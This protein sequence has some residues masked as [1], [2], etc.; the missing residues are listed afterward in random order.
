MVPIMSERLVLILR[1]CR[2]VFIVALFTSFLGVPAGL[3]QYHLSANTTIR[4]DSPRQTLQSF[5]ALGREL[6]LVLQEYQNNRTSQVRARISRIGDEFLSLIDLSSVPEASRRKRGLETGYYLLDILGRI[7]PP[8]FEDVPGANSFDINV[9]KP[10]KWRIPNTPIEIVRMR[11]GPRLGEFLFGG[12]TVVTAPQFYQEIKNLK[13]KSILPIQSWSQTLPQLT[14]PMLPAGLASSMPQILRRPWL[15]TP[16][17]KILGVLALSVVSISVIIIWNHFVWPRQSDESLPG[18]FR[19]LLTPVLIIVLMGALEN[20]VAFQ[21]N[22]SGAFAT[23]FSSVATLVTY[24]A[25][26]W[27]LWLLISLLVEAIIRSPNIPDQSLDAS[28][29][30]LC[31]RIL[32]IV[33]GVGILAYAGN[34]LGLPVFSLIAGLGIGGIA[35]ALAVRPTLENLVGG[36]ILYADRPVRVGDYCGFGNYIG[37]IESIGMRSTQVRALDRTLI[38]VPNAKFAD[39]EIVNWAHCDRMLINTTIGL[40]YETEADHLRYVLAK[41]REML[42]AHPK[43]DKETVRVR[44]S[45]YGASSLDVDIRVYALTREWNEFYAIREDVLLRV[46]EIVTNSGTGFA[47]PS[48]TLYVGRD[49]GLNPKRA[50]A[51]INQVKAWR[52]DGELPFPEMSQTKADRLSG[53]LDYPPRG[54]PNSVSQRAQEQESSEP[55]SAEAEPGPESE[56]EGKSPSGFSPENKK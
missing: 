22:I 39:M 40:R 29:L 20:F 55:L 28:L 53:T 54:S 27:I 26:A 23:T 19:R 25:A 41:L 52:E 12:E 38:S 34:A 16:V 42:T 45:S 50:Q 3:G 17:W 33:G 6:E 56:V 30:R 47:F 51:A 7:D 44:F 13:L 8:P 21:V 43:I 32:G 15:G 5:L 2:F 11:Q 46:N 36:L 35:V 31:A 18:M 49:N 9:L 4:T 24:L 48:R 1:T 14:G 37:T 10:A